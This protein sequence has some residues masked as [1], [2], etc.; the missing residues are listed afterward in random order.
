MRPLRLLPLILLLA[1]P[2]EPPADEDPEPTPY[3][4]DP[5]TLSF[6]APTAWDVPIQDYLDAGEAELGH[7]DFLRGLHALDVYDDRLYFGFG[8]ANLNLGR[9]FPVEVRAYSD[10]SPGAWSSEFTTDE[11]QVDRFRRSNDGLLVPGIDATEDAWLGNVYATFPGV[12]WFK[13]RTVDHR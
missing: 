13:S 10:D 7:T 2:A 8:D 11:E 3:P 4:T 5:S 6:E 1:C 12:P 9:V